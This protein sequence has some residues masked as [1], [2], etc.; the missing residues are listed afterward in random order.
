MIHKKG[1][2]KKVTLIQK[3][4]KPE[5][6]KGM[7]ASWVIIDDTLGLYRHKEKEQDFFVVDKLVDYI[8]SEVKDRGYFL[9]TE[10]EKTQKVERKPDDDDRWKK[11]EKM[12]V[13]SMCAKYAV[14][15]S[16]KGPAFEQ[17]FKKNFDVILTEVYKKIDEL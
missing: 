7:F 3:D 11:T 14:D 8:Q 6:T 5:K 10:P 16:D 17:S 4:G 1:T 15:V 13:I 2:V 9:F 12:K